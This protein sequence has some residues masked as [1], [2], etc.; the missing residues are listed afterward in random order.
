MSPRVPTK[1]GAQGGCLSADSM[2]RMVQRRSSVSLTSDRERAVVWWEWAESSSACHLLR[3]SRV[4]P[5]LSPRRSFDPRGVRVVEPPCSFLGRGDAQPEADE[6]VEESVAVVVSLEP[7]AVVVRW[8]PAFDVAF[9]VVLAP[10]VLVGD[11]IL[12]VL[13][14]IAQRLNRGFEL[15]IPCVAGRVFG[16]LFGCHALNRTEPL[17][18]VEREFK[19]SFEREFP[20]GRR[21]CGAGENALGRHEGKT[22]NDQALRPLGGSV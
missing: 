21:G 19:K 4:L 15:H 17:G 6:F 10:L 16:V 22:L 2:Q 8:L 5:P 12:D 3:R 7:V 13:L 20:S 14:Q 11:D 9:R 18:F 1:I